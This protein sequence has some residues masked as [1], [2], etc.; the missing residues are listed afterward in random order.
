MVQALGDLRVGVAQV[1]RDRRSDAPLTAAPCGFFR[2]ELAL[3]YIRQARRS[4]LGNHIRGAE[5]ERCY[6]DDVGDV[7]PKVSVTSGQLV[8]SW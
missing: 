1:A 7:T 2:I 4:E 8:P 6:A 3:R 5:L